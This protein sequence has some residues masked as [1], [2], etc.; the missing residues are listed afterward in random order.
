LGKLNWLVRGTRPDPA[1]VVHKLSQYCHQPYQ[2]HWAGVRRIFRYLKYAQGLAIC[3][4]QG[5]ACLHGYSDAD[6]AADPQDR[7]ST[8]GYAFLL[9]GATVT[10]ASRKQQSISTSTTEA[11]YVGL[12]NAGKE[13]V[14]IQNLLQ[15]VGRK[16]YAGETQAILLYGDNQGAIRLAAN[17]EFHARSKH[18]D[19]QYH[20]IRELVE[21]DTVKLEYIQT[22]EMAADCL[23]KPL[24]RV[25]HQVNLKMLGMVE[26]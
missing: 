24:K 26:G 17:P 7:K 18:I 10:W 19:V 2:K 12:C 1:F 25:Q 15:H 20:Y 9:G 14:W 5:T 11:E 16:E 8:M 13:A 21:N 23:T 4:G 22:S 6:F 3:Y